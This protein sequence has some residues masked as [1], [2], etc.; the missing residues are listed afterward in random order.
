LFFFSYG[1]HII[2]YQH[3]IQFNSVHFIYL[4]ANLTAKR[5]ITKRARIEKKK[6][7]THTNREQ[8]QGNGNNSIQFLI[9]LRAELNSRGP[10]TESARNK[11]TNNNT[12]TKQNTKKTIII[13]I[14]I[15]NYSDIF[16]V[17]FWLLLHHRNAEDGWLLWEQSTSLRGYLG[18][19]L[20]SSVFHDVVT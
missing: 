4:R 20:I 1:K 7:N 10:I 5:P 13:I 9:Y 16:G 8:K 19:N 2:L 11:K 17:Y 3:I 6:K 18:N 14:I 15:I 12:T